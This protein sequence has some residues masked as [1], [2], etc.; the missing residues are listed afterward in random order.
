VSTFTFFKAVQ[1]LTTVLCLP[2][3]S[4]SCNQLD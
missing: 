3:C 1:A 4:Y 2:A